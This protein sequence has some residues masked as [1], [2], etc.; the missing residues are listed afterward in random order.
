MLYSRRLD[1]TCSLH[2][3]ALRSPAPSSTYEYFVR[4]NPDFLLEVAGEYMQHVGT[5]P[6]D[7]SPFGQYIFALRH[8]VFWKCIHEE[9]GASFF[10]SE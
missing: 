9:F 5:E 8:F 3:K 1:E 10:F 4:F 2:I 7:A 6:M